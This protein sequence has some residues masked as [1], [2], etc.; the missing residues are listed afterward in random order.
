MFS[1][2]PWAEPLI[3]DY[4]N[5]RYANCY[6]G[7]GR[8]ASEAIA[9]VVIM[10]MLYYGH[11]VLIGRWSMKSLQTSN[12]RIMK[13]VIKQTGYEK[14][15]NINLKSR[16]VCKTTGAVCDFMGIHYNIEDWRSLDNYQ[17]IWLEE[18]NL[19]T[20]Y[21]LEVILPSLR[22]AQMTM[23]NSWNP[24]LEDGAIEIMLSM[25]NALNFFKIYE[26]NPMFPQHLEDLRLATLST[27]SVAKYNWMWLGHYL[28]QG[29][30]CPFSPGK[31]DEALERAYLI[32]RHTPTGQFVCGVDFAW[33]DNDTSDY[34]G[35]VKV[36][37]SGNLIDFRQFREADQAERHRI[38]K[39]FT[40]GAFLTLVDDDAVGHA[41]V[42]DAR[43]DSQCGDTRG[44]KFTNPSK[45]NLVFNAND[46]LSKGLVTL[47]D[48]KP[49]A[50][51]LKNL[52]EDEHGRYYAGRGHDDLAFAWMLCCEAL[53]YSGA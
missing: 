11:N 23:F 43:R 17:V 9:R 34:T 45:G 37:L 26:D 36:D 41:Y 7:R 39:E 27:K 53:R 5:Y 18:P 16:I 13:R 22:D 15:F 50:D 19:I 12:M 31:I 21:E 49:I 44:Y 51:E 24:T 47:K 6:G 35:L 48:G 38:T 42:Q 3:K 4:G 32:S 8:G 14:Y 1:V 40:K 30:L 28:P 20:E 46:R 10:A 25:P 29:E 2:A 33:S 52:V